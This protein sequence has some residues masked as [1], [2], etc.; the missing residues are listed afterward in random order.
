[1]STENVDAPIHRAPQAV[2]IHCATLARYAGRAGP[3]EPSC[4]SFELTE[5]QIWP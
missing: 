3:A 4:S 1:M 5:M 2:T